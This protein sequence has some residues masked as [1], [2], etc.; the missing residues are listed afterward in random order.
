[1]DLVLTRGREGVQNLKNLA[2]VICE[3]P[4]MTI[5]TD[6]LHLAHHALEL[7]IF[8]LFTSVTSNIIFTCIT[9][10]NGLY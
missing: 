1:M 3:W 10:K 5:F 9:I 8:S 7:T 4:P 6:Y 2:D